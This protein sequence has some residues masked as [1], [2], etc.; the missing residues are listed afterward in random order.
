MENK[1]KAKSF[2]AS[3]QLEELIE[4]ALASTLPEHWEALVGFEEVKNYESVVGKLLLEE[5]KVLLYWSKIPKGNKKNL[6]LSLL[7]AKLFARLNSLKQDDWI[8]LR[9]GGKICLVDVERYGE[10]CLRGEVG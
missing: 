8:S 4:T 6:L 3:L 1:E 9:K 2:L 10:C 7:F 5:K